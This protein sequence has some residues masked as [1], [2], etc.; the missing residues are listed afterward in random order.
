MKRAAAFLALALLLT[1][2]A[3]HA[4]GLAPP[5]RLA[6]GVQ[7]YGNLDYDSAAALLRAA[8]DSAGTPVLSDSQRVRALVYL[9][10]TELFRDHRD[11]ASAAFRRLL[12]LDPDYRPDQLVFPPEVSSLFQ[13]VRLTT[14]AVTVAAPSVTR[15]VSAGD[16]LVIWLY[17]TSYHP[18]DVAVLRANGVPLRNLYSG[19]VGDSL[20]VLWDGRGETGSPAESGSYRLRVDS[21]GDDGRVVRSVDVPLDVTQLRPDTL[22]LPAPPA[23]SQ[24]LPEHTVA[25]T[26]ARALATGLAAAAAAMVLP[27]VVSSGTPAMGERFAVAGALGVAGVVGYQLQRRPQPIPEN[28]AAN[29]EL[30]RSWQQQADSVRALNATRLRAVRYEIRAGAPRVVRAP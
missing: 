5:A 8:L 4:Q 23:A 6:A 19:G 25:T 22:P 27:S 20:Q 2:A 10:A 3:A 15:I 30:R 9:G 28:I 26:G 1:G 18:V 11:S 14:R 13:E 7:S 17:A 24:L 21:R 12:L 16:R 29:Q